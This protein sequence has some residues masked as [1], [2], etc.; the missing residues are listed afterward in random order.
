[1]PMPVPDGTPSSLQAAADGGGFAGDNITS[2]SG[3]GGGNITAASS[4]HAER[5][6]Q[7]GGTDHGLTFIPSLN[8]S[9]DDLIEEGNSVLH[10]GN[11]MVAGNNTSDAIM[12]D[13]TAHLKRERDEAPAADARTAA[14]NADLFSDMFGDMRDDEVEEEQQDEQFAPDEYFE[15]EFYRDQELAAA[16][17]RNKNQ[18]N[19]G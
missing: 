17:A 18:Q 9:L 13:E 15:G 1:M 16:A 8:M 5:T 7:P 4:C 2:M 14:D 11:A 6:T 12:N 3:G 19:Q 10:E